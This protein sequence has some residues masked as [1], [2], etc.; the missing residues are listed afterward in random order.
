MALVLLT[1]TIANASEVKSPSV[2]LSVPTVT[3]TQTIGAKVQGSGPYSAL[4]VNSDTIGDIAIAKFGCDCP[5]CRNQALQMIQ[6]G[7]ISLTR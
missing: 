7:K 2:P 6:L 1:V 5:A 4:D 3:D